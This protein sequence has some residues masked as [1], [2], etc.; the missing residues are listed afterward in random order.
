V[1]KLREG[2]DRERQKY[3]AR[4]GRIIWR[5]LMPKTRHHVCYRVNE[6]AG[7]VEILLVWNAVAAATPEL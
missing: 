5:L 7:A 2:T 6:A 4:G 1:A 3:A